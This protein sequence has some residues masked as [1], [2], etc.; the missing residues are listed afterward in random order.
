VTI[1]DRMRRFFEHGYRPEIKSHMVKARDHLIEDGWATFQYSDILDELV[2]DCIGWVVNARSFQGK[3][4]IW[5]GTFGT[6]EE[7]LTYS[8]NK[9]DMY[10]GAK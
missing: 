7:A 2:T 6:I 5:G 9:L 10:I 1:E 3:P 8:E 4:E